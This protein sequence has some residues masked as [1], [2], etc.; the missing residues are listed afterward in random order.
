MKQIKFLLLLTVL[1]AGCG[2]SPNVDAMKVGLAKSGLPADQAACFAEAA[3]KTV[4]GEPYN[5]LADLLN[6]GVKESEAVSKTR[7]KYSADFKDPLD[8]ARAECVKAVTPAGA[9]G[10]AKSAAPVSPASPAKK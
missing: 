5:Y 8:K 9:A 7:R 2:P 6:A 10:T 4:K 3:S 1:L